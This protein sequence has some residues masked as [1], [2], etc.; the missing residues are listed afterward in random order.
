M[1]VEDSVVEDRGR[2]ERYFLKTRMSTAEQ[3]EEEEEEDVRDGS[4]LVFVVEALERRRRGRSKR[5]RDKGEHF[6][7][8]R[9]RFIRKPKERKENNRAD[10]CDP[11]RKLYTRRC[12]L[13][14]APELGRVAV[15]AF[16]PVVGV[17]PTNIRVDRGCGG[18]Y[19]DRKYGERTGEHDVGHGKGHESEV[20]AEGER[21]VRAEEGV[22][23]EATAVEGD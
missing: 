19:Y 5:L 4:N 1:D 21:G 7:V 18:V 15:H 14:Q 9:L 16:I 12:R 22:E 11:P 8:V 3:E 2:G 17:R 23:F 20:P 10:R 13:V 6:G